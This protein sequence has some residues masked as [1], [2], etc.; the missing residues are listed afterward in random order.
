MGNVAPRRAAFTLLE[1]LAVSAIVA[2]LAGL[3]LPA[4]SRTREKSRQATCG[5]NLRQIGQAVCLYADDYGVLPTAGLP[6]GYLLWNGTDYILYGRLL[7]PPGRS[8]ARLFFCPSATAFTPANSATG[9]GNLG[10]AGRVTAGAYYQRGALDGAPTRLD[11]ATSSLIADL[12]LPDTR[13]HPALL[14]VLNSDGSVHPLSPPALWSISASNA[15]S[16]LD[17]RL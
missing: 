9:L 15:W 6:S 3:L 13:N 8:L 17:T 7:T 1:L 10:A 14:N 12:Y 4:L 2:M 5:A 16:Q 11:S